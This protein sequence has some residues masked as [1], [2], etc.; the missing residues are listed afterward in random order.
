MEM[1]KITVAVICANDKVDEA[2]ASG[3]DKVGSE[4][5][6][7]TINNGKIDFDILVCTPDICQKL[8]NL[9]KF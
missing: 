4:D 1:E 9:E 7:E 5:L 8:E 2:K 6:I 3:A